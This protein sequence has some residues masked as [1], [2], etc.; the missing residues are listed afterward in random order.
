MLGLGTEFTASSGR[1]GLYYLLAIDAFGCPKRDTVAV[2]D[3]G[4]DVEAEDLTICT[5][6]ASACWWKTSTR[7]MN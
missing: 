6:T 3:L 4:I 7:R 2:F 5:V 1:P